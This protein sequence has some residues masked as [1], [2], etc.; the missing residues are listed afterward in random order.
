MTEASANLKGD[1]E[2]SRGERGRK[3]GKQGEGVSSERERDVKSQSVPL[4]VKCNI[5][6]VG[7]FYDLRF[8]ADFSNGK[9][10]IIDWWQ[11]MW[12]ADI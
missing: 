4:G 11:C 3:R 1:C 6:S 7:A 12:Q 5:C 8:Y 9:R 10:S 2:E